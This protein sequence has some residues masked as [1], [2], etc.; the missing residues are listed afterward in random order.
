[1]P[2]LPPAAVIIPNLDSPVVDRAVDAVCA[3]VGATPLAIVVVGLDR[4]GRLRG[5]GRV[6]RVE[7]DGPRPPGAA[8]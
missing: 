5:D 8:R 4:P 1:M 7:T 6:R 2:T 3:Q